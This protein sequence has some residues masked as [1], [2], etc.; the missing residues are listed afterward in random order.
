MKT[1]TILLFLSLPLLGQTLTFV[2]GSPT[3]NPLSWRGTITFN[4]RNPVSCALIGRDNGQHMIVAYR[5]Q[6]DIVGQ[7][8]VVILTAKHRDDHFFKPQ[9]ALVEMSPQPQSD[10]TWPDFCDLHF[11]SGGFASNNLPTAHIKTTFVQFD[12]GTVWGPAE[13]AQETRHQRTAAIEYLNML[14]AAYTS[15]GSDGLAK[16]LA[17]PIGQPHGT[18]WNIRIGVLD[19]WA[20]LSKLPDTQSQVELINTSLALAASRSAWLK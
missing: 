9:D 11:P 14:K 5:V 15:G 7:D 12:D 1:L 2:D 3:D 8:G 18:A 19:Q 16:A 20:M 6:F 10:Y 4:G 17:Q 13:I